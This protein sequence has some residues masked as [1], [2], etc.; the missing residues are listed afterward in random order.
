[1]SIIQ[2]TRWRDRT[3]HTASGAYGFGFTPE[4]I[5]HAFDIIHAIENDKRI[6]TQGSLGSGKSHPT[7]HFLR[8]SIV[9]DAAWGVRGIVR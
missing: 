3:H 1:M 5:A 6:A 8:T 4:L 9:V 2:Y 7:R